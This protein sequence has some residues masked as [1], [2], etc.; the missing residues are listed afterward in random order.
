MAQRNFNKKNVKDDGCIF[1]KIVKG[2]IPSAKIYEDDKVL[3]FL[4]IKPINAGHVLV[5][6]KKHSE[7][8][9]DVKVNDLCKMA[10]VMKK[11]NKVLRDGEINAK[12]INLFYADGEVAGQEIPHAHIHII[13]RYLNDGFGLKFPTKYGKVFSAKELEKIA[14]KIKL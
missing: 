3:A 14:K 11:I 9:K 7:L 10:E 2:E 12:G 5:I 1:C 8:L 13:P 6:P 4:D